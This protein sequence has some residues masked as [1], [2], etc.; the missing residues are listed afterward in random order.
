MGKEKSK[1]VSGLLWRFGERFAAEGVSFIVA[2]ILARLLLPEYYGIISIV[3][4]FLV[5]IKAVIQDGLGYALIQKKDADR[6]DFSTVFYAQMVLSIGLYALVFLSAPLVAEWYG[7]PI[8]T[9]VFRTMALNLPIGAFNSVQQAYVSRKMQFKR[10]FFAT[11]I[12][13]LLS[14]GIGI[15][16][17]YAGMGV[18]ALVSQDLSNLICDTLV[19]WF[20]VKWRPT[21]QFSFARLMGMLHYSW[22]LTVTTMIDNLYNSL[23]PMMIGKLF[24]TTQQGY[25]DRGDIIPNTIASNAATAFKSVLLSAFSKEQSDR[26][27]LKAMLRRS[28][29][30]AAFIFFPL[31]AGLIAAARPIILILLDIEWEE[32]VVFLRY[33]SLFFAFV[34]LN[35]INQQAISAIGRSD[36]SLKLELWKKVTGILCLIIGISFG[37]KGLL[38][39]KAISS[40]L[41]LIFTAVPIRKLFG[42][43]FSEQLK[44]VLPSA[45]LSAFMGITVWCIDLTGWENFAVLCLQAVSGVTI[46]CLGAKILKFECFDEL[47]KKVM[48]RKK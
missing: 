20:T 6:L 39:G 43:S 10:F 18:W 24:G 7:E 26:E 27:Y 23:C 9:P 38:A 19:L 46:Y 21:L 33:C 44:D 37:V 41:G 36:V 2:Q 25:Y 5:I 30:M 4:V 17:A 3:R 32:S 22:K 48:K 8:L 15:G 1:V 35:V 11:I 12:G 29:R 28:L 13:T 16:M 42:Y 14:A 45:L 31:M 34:P 40:V 47:L